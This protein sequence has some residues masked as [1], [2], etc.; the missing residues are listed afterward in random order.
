VTVIAADIAAHVVFDHWFGLGRSSTHKRA[1]VL[2]ALYRANGAPMTASQLAA[3]TGAKV[4][5]VIT[6]HIPEL[7][8]ALANEA[9]DFIPGRGYA[10]TENGMAECRA[11]LWTLG[12]EMR[13]AI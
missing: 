7:R 11:A 8:S 4:G 12:E 1:A 5:S 10:L 9:L 6:R 3:I 13:A 2:L